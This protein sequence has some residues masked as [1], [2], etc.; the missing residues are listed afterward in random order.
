MRFME[1]AA[2]QDVLSITCNKSMIFF[3]CKFDLTETIQQANQ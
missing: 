3:A 1:H 2:I